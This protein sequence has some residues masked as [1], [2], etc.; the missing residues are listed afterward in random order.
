HRE[1]HDDAV[2]ATPPECEYPLSQLSERAGRCGPRRRRGLD[3]TPVERGDRRHLQRWQVDGRRLP[4]SL[5]HFVPM[6]CLSFLGGTACQGMLQSCCGF[7]ISQPLPPLSA[8]LLISWARYW[9]PY[10]DDFQYIA[11]NQGRILAS[12]FF[13]L[14]IACSIVPLVPMPTSSGWFP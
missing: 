13:S 6:R 1:H 4:A 14:F 9:G 5:A 10:S 7:H 11:C 8:A 2:D 12:G 3:T